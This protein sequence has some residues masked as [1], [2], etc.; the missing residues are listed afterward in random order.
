M[1]F[2]KSNHQLRQGNNDLIHKIVLTLLITFLFLLSSYAQNSINYKALVKDASGNILAS[3]PISI[4]FIIYEGAALTN[5]V[6]Q[7]SHTI[8]TNANGIIIVNIGEGVTAGNFS[9]IN[10]QD[11]EHFLNVQINTGS[12]LVDLGTTQFKA[13][14]YALVAKDIENKVWDINGNN[15]FYNEGNV[16][17]GTNLPNAKLD[18][19]GSGTDN[20]SA[21]VTSPIGTSSLELFHPNPSIT[22]WSITSDVSNEFQITSSNNDLVSSDVRFK[23]KSNG[24][25]LMAE[26]EGRVG[27]GIV[28][29][30]NTFSVLQ[31]TGIEN[32]VRIETFD[33]PTGKD[34]LELKVPEGSTS[35]SQFIEM[36]NGGSIVAAIN[37]DGSAEFKSIQFEDNTTQTT[38]AVGPV[39]YG[40]VISNG[41]VSSGSG[42]F[43]VIWNASLNR[44][45]ITISNVDY[46][47][48]SFA[49]NVTASSSSIHRC[50]VSSQNG[51]ML[52]YL[53]N[54]AGAPIQGEFQFTTFQ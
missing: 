5:N 38:A 6:Y 20:T 40:F 9:S 47:Y 31:A 26:N 18:I 7:E 4:Q 51:N 10:W 49:S 15:T 35:G 48:R 14:P 54:S 17:I 37:S 39:A 45:E 29:P 16:G 3:Q 23:L 25:I 21:R 34:L 42:N 44:Y 41:T 8:N 53:Y 22:D 32:T 13:V 1:T 50:R 19:V 27:I 24:D 30:I 2:S 36:E 52:V 33:H 46:F 11:D 43:S 12:G 28:N